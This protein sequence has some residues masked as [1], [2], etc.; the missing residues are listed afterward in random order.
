[1]PQVTPSGANEFIEEQLDSLAEKIE[2]LLDMDLL[3]YTGPLVYGVDDLV[4]DA[5]ESRTNRRQSLVVVLETTGG[6][7]EPV[8]RMVNVFRHNYGERVEFIVPSYAM[9]AGTVLAMS[10][11]AIHMDYYS[12]L[13]PIDPQVEGSDGGLVPA[14]GYLVQ[15]NRLLKKANEKRAS[16]AEIALLMNFDQA[17][18]YQ[19][20]QDRELSIMLLREWL[21][22]YLFKNLALLP[23]SKIAKAKRVAGKLNDTN[24]WHAHGH[25]ITMQVLQN[26]LDLTIEDFALPSKAPLSDHIRGYHRLLTDYMN[27][28]GRQSCVHRPHRIQY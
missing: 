26:D 5:V 16:S 15:Y 6:Y 13:G 27:R 9:S 7:I 4:R 25:G 2:S 10:G 3:A 28:L 11:D 14:L 23:A 17:E 22:K 12:V 20:E 21:A 19:Y 1:M 18:L 8:R 24:R